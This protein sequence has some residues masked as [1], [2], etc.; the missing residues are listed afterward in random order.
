MMPIGW[1]AAKIETQPRKSVHRHADQ[2]SI[3][4]LKLINFVA[5][6]RAVQANPSELLQ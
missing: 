6:G 1:T 4:T 3:A 5:I 2:S